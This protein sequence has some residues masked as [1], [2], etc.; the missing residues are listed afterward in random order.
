M[1]YLDAINFGNKILKFKKINTYSLDTELL[2]S[3]V[4]NCTREQLLINLNK[5]IKKNKFNKF[6]SLI[7][8]RVTNEPI[9]YIFKKKEFWKYNF[10]VNNQVLIPRPE[11]E[12]IVEQVLKQSNLNNSKIILDI[13]TG[14]GC[15]LLSIIKERPNF[16]GIAIDI[17]RKAL[18][19]AKYNAKMHQLENK[20]KFI[21][22]DIDK[23]IYNK[24]DFIVSNPPYVK[25]IDLKR[26]DNNVKHFEPFIALSG[27]SDGLSEIKKII[28]KS[29]KL[30]KKNGKLIFEIGNNQN[31]NV[32]NLL[33]KNG[34]IINKICKDIH[35]YP[36]V[37]ISSKNI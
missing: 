16:Y 1:N 6:I 14:S 33:K 24:Y 11:T 12:I 20:V 10:K 13:G 35:S 22:I 9:A 19:V 36:R 27:G 21:N 23:F 2:L 5:K 3:K 8:R 31:K 15:L 30:L 17:C 4:L 26:L 29:K 25:N 34:F 37:I 32:I 7:S 28:L 18:N